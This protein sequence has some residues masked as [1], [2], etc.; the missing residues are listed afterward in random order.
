MTDDARVMADLT[1]VERRLLDDLDAIPGRAP[2]EKFAGEL[3]R[4]LTRNIWRREGEAHELSPSFR[5]AEWL[6]NRWRRRHGKPPL[7]LAWSGGEGRVD[8]TVEGELG[9][10][11]WTHR[12]LPTDHRHPAHRGL[13]ESPPRPNHGAS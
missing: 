2:D 10:L 4:A 12:P 7:D 9:R 5:R 1:A 3:Y 11:G 13:P 6:V 8:R